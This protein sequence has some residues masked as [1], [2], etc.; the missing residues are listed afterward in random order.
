MTTTLYFVTSLPRSGTTSLCEMANICGLKSL[1]VLK[2]MSF[3]QSLDCG[4][5][6]FADT[7][8]YSPE[9]LMGL[10]ECGL[11][12][13]YLIKFVYSHTKKDDHL[14]SINK[15][16]SIWKPSKRFKLK[17]DLMDILCHRNIVLTD[18]NNYIDKHYT[19]IKH[20]SS[21]Y[22]I[23]LLDFSFRNG[24]NQFCKY[25][26]KPIPNISIPHKN[27]L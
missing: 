11:Q 8:F 2:S 26:D 14:K 25:L 10:L 9:F 3:K 23:S 19:Y 21:F 20:I 17:I 24:W 4:Y 1:H 6:F 15:L 5:V 18:K 7:P 13:K 16:Y 22:G 27:K 12:E